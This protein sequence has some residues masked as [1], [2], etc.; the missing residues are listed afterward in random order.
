MIGRKSLLFAHAIFSSASWLVSGRV[1]SILFFSK[2]N[3]VIKYLIR[4][5]VV[6]KYLI[7]FSSLSFPHIFLT[8]VALRPPFLSFLLWMSPSGAWDGYDWR[9]WFSAWSSYLPST[10][11]LSVT[12]GRHSELKGS[13]WFFYQK[14]RSNQ[15]RSL[16]LLSS[17]ILLSNLRSTKWGTKTEELKWNWK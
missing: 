17:E 5:G 2:G 6:P 16:T 15:R 13:A 8:K 12:S 11:N 3:V 10:R 1:Y 7:R 14:F 9:C 4:G